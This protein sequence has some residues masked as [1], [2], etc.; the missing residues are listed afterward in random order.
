VGGI[1]HIHIAMRIK[2]YQH[3]GVRTREQPSSTMFHL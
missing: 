1:S 3:P 2:P